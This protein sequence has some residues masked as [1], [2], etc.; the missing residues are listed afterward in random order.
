MRMLAVILTATTVL[1][2][3][4]QVLCG[5]WLAAKGATPEG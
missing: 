2:L 5:L 3:A 4:S 1:L